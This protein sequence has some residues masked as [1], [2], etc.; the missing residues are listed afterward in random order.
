M[1]RGGFTIWL[2]GLPCSGK[3]TIAR[4]VCAEMC[5]AGFPATLI[6]GDEVR[7]RLSKD[8]GYSK[9]DRFEN[10]SRISY[11]AESLTRVGAIP[12]I[13]AISPYRDSREQAR[14]EIQRFIEVYVHCP[15]EV[16]IQRDVKGHYQK[17]IRG[18]IQAFTGISDPYEAPISP[19]VI[20]KT[21]LES[22]EQCSLKILRTLVEL[23]YI[24]MEDLPTRARE[25]S[26]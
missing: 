16:C 10:V 11:L 2:T 25:I 3:S 15:V 9:E 26:R 8:L 21:H 22:P 23:Q 20:L 4:L 1:K 12:I 17:A 5:A 7:Q 19:E 14:K 24:L 13:A 18:E 6:D